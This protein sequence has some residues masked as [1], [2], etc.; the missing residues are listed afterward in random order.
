MR[1]RVANGAPPRAHPASTLQRDLDRHRII[2]RVTDH[3]TS[4]S[5]PSSG[6]PAFATTRWSVVARAQ[7]HGD[8]PLR[9]A[10]LSTLCE[11]YWYPVYAF[12]RRRG[13]GAEDARDLV[14]SFFTRFLERDD[15]ASAD[16][17]RGRFR[18]FL[19]GCFE[20]FASNER[21]RAQAQKRGGGFVGFS[22]DN[23]FAENR[24]QFEPVENEDAERIFIRSWARTL[25]EDVVERLRE[26]YD[27]GGKSELF[28]RLKPVLQ[29]DDQAQVYGDLAQSL[30]TTEGAIKVAVY[31]L[32]KRFGEILRRT[33]ADTVTDPAQVEDELQGLFEA[34]G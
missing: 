3:R 16:A 8:E 23:D 12:A 22:L 17:E 20:N 4:S 5:S 29:G 34:L 18:S 1:R 28:E 2:R 11:S 30:D 14:Q 10:A 21:D 13:H 24:Y 15:L 7:S 26:E 9:R 19:L 31:R 27:N 6:S 33:I 32:R 25:L